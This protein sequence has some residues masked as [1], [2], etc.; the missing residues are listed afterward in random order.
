MS[1]QGSDQEEYEDQ[2]AEDDEDGMDEETF[3]HEEFLPCPTEGMIFKSKESLFAF[4]QRT[5]QTERVWHYEKISNIKSVDY[6]RYV[7][8]GCDKGRKYTKRRQSKMIDC[9]AKVNAL[10]LHDSSWCVSMV[11]REYNHDLNAK[12]SHFMTS[13]REVSR[14]LK[15]HIVA[16]DIADLRPYKSIRLLEVQVGDLEN[17]RCTPKGC[18]NYIQQQRRLRT[19]TTDG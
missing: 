17:M 7:L 8:F 4:L 16:H 5:R 18:G 6:I 3:T 15:R 14:S 9:K 1:D 11:I 12:L 19:L 13:H 2:E 10:L